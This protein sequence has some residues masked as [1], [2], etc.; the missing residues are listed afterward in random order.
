MSLFAL[1]FIIVP[2]FGEFSF[3]QSNVSLSSPALAIAET[4]RKNRATKG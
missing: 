3:S 2:S 1:T 4:K